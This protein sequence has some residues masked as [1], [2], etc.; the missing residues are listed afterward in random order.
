ME[1]RNLPQ[2]NHLTSSTP[3]VLLNI[4]QWAPVVK[5]QINPHLHVS[6]I[7]WER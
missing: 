7:C 3:R 4:P 5:Q 1:F 2:H 6:F